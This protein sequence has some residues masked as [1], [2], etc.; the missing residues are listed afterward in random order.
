M[1]RSLY[2]ENVEFSFYD[3]FNRNLQYSYKKQLIILHYI[4]AQKYNTGNIYFFKCYFF[5][6]Y[7]DFTDLLYLPAIVLIL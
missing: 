2:I 5:E 6:L 3:D 7:V 4:I 1:N